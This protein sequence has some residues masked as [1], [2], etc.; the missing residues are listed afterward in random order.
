MLY[1]ILRFFGRAI[2]HQLEER[3][4]VID[5]LVMPICARCTGI[6][7]GV[8]TTIL[9]ILLT[10]RYK[11]NMIPNIPISLLLFF[12]LSP[13]AFDGVSS[14]LHL[15]PSDNFLR[16]VTGIPFGIVLPFFLFPLLNYSEKNDTS[17]RI[18]DKWY[19]I[20][21]PFV[22][23][24]FIGFLVYNSYVPYYVISTLV[25][26]TLIIWFSLIIFMLIKRIAFFKKG[27]YSF[28]TSIILGIMVLTSLSFIADALYDFLGIG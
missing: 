5:G 23:A 17:I 19:Q 2:C 3:S 28:N 18:V 1:D 14:Y 27:I 4:F 10:K 26:L 22:G 12:L 15:R 24:S 6:Y 20:I 7:I 21:P 11:S 13:M 25:I 9:Y 16:I 8:F